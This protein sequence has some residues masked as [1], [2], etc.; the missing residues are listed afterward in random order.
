MKL[1]LL[2]APAGSDAALEAALNA[3]AGAV[4]F[5]VGTLNMRS[6]AAVNFCESDLDRVAARCHEFGA[7]AYL[8]LNIVVFNNELERVAA[9]CRAAKKA[10]VDAVIAADPAVIAEAGRNDLPV[11][12]SVQANVANI[13]TV[14]FYSSF[15][16][17]MVLAR[18]LKLADI[19]DIVNRIAAENITSPSGRKVGTEL[20]I[21]GALCSSFSGK[22]YLSLTAANCSANRGVCRQ[23]C[24]RRYI[25]TDAETGERL[26]IANGYVMSAAD[27]CMIDFMPEVV[28]SGVDILKIEGRGRSADYVA[29]VTRVYRQA[30]EAC[31]AG[32]FTR[33]AAAKWRDE[34]SRVFNRGFWRGGYY[35]GEDFGVWSGSGGNRSPVDKTMIGKVTDYYARIGVAEI[36]LSAGELKRGD[37]LLIVGGTTGALELT[38]P[39]FRIGDG[40]TL[41]SFAPKGAAVAFPLAT[42]VR[43][44]DSVYRLD[45]R[46]F[47]GIERKI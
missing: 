25:V 6:G 11:H 36:R 34:L 28:A 10:G 40:K 47:S 29:T 22:C 37:R 35:L 12:L 30:L 42:R 14:R 17:V 7:K 24:R 23:S 27:L 46:D 19:R 33:A 2:M 26:E 21:H 32:T 41:E 5:G 16:E 39:E 9:L 15:A 31:A 13:E 45:D 20:F 3:G 4:Y 1:P 8:T 18:E 43:A 38:A 44:G